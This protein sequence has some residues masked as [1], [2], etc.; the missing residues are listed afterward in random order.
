MKKEKKARRD[1][2]DSAAADAVVIRAGDPLPG[3]GDAG[4]AGAWP[5]GAGQVARDAIAAEEQRKAL[6]KEK[7]AAM[8]KRMKEKRR[9]KFEE[10]RMAADAL[11]KSDAAA[12]LWQQFCRWAGPDKLTALE[13][14]AEQWSS[15]NVGFLRVGEAADGDSAALIDAVRSLMPDAYARAGEGRDGVPGVSVLLVA[16]SGL[17][18]AQLGRA[19]YDGKPVGK[20]FSK[21]ISKEEQRAWLA[22]NGKKKAAPTGVGTARRLHVLC[23]EG[24]LSLASTSVF[25]IDMNRDKKLQTVLDMTATRDEL[26]DFINVHLR[27]LV[28]AGQIRILLHS[29]Q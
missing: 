9:V 4:T 26:C 7:M 6:H 20:L 25:V 21:H 1:E 18:A 16:A 3:G 10:E 5:E 19:M 17:R 14:D 27:P 22:A 2:G 29:S 13:R 15:D 24:S 11:M 28:K 8:N 23:D 12:F